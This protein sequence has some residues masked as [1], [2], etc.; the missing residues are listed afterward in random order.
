LATSSKVTSKVF[1]GGASASVNSSDEDQ[2]LTISQSGDSYDVKMP[3][4]CDH[5]RSARSH[6]YPASAKGISANVLTDANGSRL[7]IDSQTTGKGTD[8]TISGNSELA[9]GYTPVNR[10]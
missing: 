3:G 7:V 1:E 6:Q 10:R 2:T 9:T 4:W 5:A 8:I